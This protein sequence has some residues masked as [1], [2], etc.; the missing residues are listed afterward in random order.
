MIAAPL[1]CMLMMCVKLHH[2]YG[3]NCSVLMS[4]IRYV[5]LLFHIVMLNIYVSER[6]LMLTNDFTLTSNQTVR[7]S[8]SSVVTADS[9]I[10]SCDIYPV[11]FNISSESG[12]GNRRVKR[13]PDIR[14]T[15]YLVHPYMI[16]SK[17]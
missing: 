1:L 5:L 8:R 12:T 3:M 7:Q 17:S 16:V 10:S 9:K 13:W 15:G 4:V 2:L 14:L 11:P 6:Q